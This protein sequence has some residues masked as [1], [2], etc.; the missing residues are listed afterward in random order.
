MNRRN[1]FFQLLFLLSSAQIMVVDEP[2]ALSELGAFVGYV[3]SQ[4]EHVS[5]LHFPGEPHKAH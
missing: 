1:L 2:A 3:A 5:R 4:K